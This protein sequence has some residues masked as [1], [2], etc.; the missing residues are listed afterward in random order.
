M[1]CKCQ[2]L[3]APFSLSSALSCVRSVEIYCNLAMNVWQLVHYTQPANRILPFYSAFV[4]NYYP[5]CRWHIWPRRTNNN[6]RPLSS[7]R[8]RICSRCDS[9]CILFCVPTRPSDPCSLPREFAVR[10]RSWS[11]LVGRYSNLFR[12]PTNSSVC[13]TSGA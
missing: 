5:M 2:G 11:L 7:T 3:S 6:G 8:Q 4:G 9:L 13:L 10:C 1:N 12:M